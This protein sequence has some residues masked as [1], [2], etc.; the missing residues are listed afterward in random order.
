MRDD[1]VIIK[2]SRAHRDAGMSRTTAWRRERDDP[3]FPRAVQIGPN[4]FGYWRSEWW[5]WLASRPRR[6]VSANAPIGARLPGRPRKS[7][8]TPEAA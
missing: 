3:S 4:R 1:D 7:A 2:R 8:K 5:E 6:N